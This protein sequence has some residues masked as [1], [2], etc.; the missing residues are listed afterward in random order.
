[1]LT[2]ATL[3]GQLPPPAVAQP[4]KLRARMTT[5]KPAVQVATAMPT[6]ATSQLK[7]VT[8]KNSDVAVL[9]R[10]T[11]LRSLQITWRS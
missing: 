11:T 5:Q 2:A 8:S 10:I 1:M 4:G 9:G 7:S 3:A 6:A